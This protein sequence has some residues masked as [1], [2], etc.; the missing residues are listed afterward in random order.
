MPPSVIRADPLLRQCG[1]GYK[2]IS[3]LIGL[4]MLPLL[5]G[6][7]CDRGGEP[8]AAIQVRWMIA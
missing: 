6:R 3:T 1:I 7:L 8:F 4:F 2:K 5:A